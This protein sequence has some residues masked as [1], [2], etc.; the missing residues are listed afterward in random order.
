MSVRS[1]L[2]FVLSVALAIPAM[3]ASAPSAEEVLRRSDEI[4]APVDFEAEMTFIT[5]RGKNE[6]RTFS[7]RMWK[8]GGDK[9]RFQ[10]LTPAEDRGAEVLRVGDN[11]WSYMPNLKRALKIGG[12]Q[13]FHG[14]DFSNSD[15]LRINLSEDYVPKMVSTSGDAYELELTAKNDEVAYA[16]VRYWI[17]KKDYMPLRGDYYTASGKLIRKLEM[18]DEKTFGKYRRPSKFVMRNMLVPSRSSEMIYNAFV[19]RKDLD[20]GLFELVALGR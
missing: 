16:R 11:Y 14:G 1:P 17:R 12:K 5:H 15:V 10:F 18:T 3:A 13:E 19:E 7:M 2:S 20:S 6:T 4:L 9:L 8:K